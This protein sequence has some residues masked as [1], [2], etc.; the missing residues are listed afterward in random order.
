VACAAWILAFPIL[1]LWLKPWSKAFKAG[2]PGLAG[3][4]GGAHSSSSGGS[5]S[6]GGSSSGGFSGGGGSFGGGGSSSSW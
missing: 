3:F 6:S 1:R 2:H 4:T 5:W